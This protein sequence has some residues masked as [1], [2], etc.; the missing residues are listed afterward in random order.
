MMNL[1]VI[2]PN[3]FYKFNDKEKEKY[4]NNVKEEIKRSSNEILKKMYNI[5]RRNVKH[6]QSDFYIHDIYLLKKYPSNFIWMTR[7]S[8]TDF[9][10]L[11]SLDDSLISWYDAVKKV[12]TDF[13]FYNG[14]TLRKITHEEMDKIIN[15]YKKD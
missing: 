12:N 8:G 3:D 9:I 15:K 5:A 1:K 10:P 11:E 6:Y 13:Y 4:I 2:N 14:K 7:K